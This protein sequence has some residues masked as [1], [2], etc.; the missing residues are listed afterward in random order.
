M[1][2]CRF[3]Q[4]GEAAVGFIL[5]DQVIPL[6]TAA[7]AAGETL[8]ATDDLLSFLPHGSQ[9][10]AAQKMDAWLAGNE[11]AAAAFAIEFSNEKVH[12]IIRQLW[13]DIQFKL[14]GKQIRKSFVRI[15]WL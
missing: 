2:L 5:D 3:E 9:H 12:F 10:D 15:S 14:N 11:S 7:D 13:L 4:Q 1:K 8:E 6:S